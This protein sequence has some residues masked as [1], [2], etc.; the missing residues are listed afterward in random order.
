MAL[1][2]G[3]NDAALVPPL[4]LPGSDASKGNHITGCK[5][6]LHEEDRNVSNNLA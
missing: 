6:I 3:H 1:A 5:E 4:Q 2:R